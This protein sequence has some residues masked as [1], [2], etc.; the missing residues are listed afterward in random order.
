[1]SVFIVAEMSCNHMG[2]LQ[3]AY[4]IIDAA[5]EAGAD[6][7]KISLDD[8]N[9]GI[10]IDCHNKYF[11]IR[12]GTW[13]GENLHDLYMRT[14]TPWRWVEGLKERAEK[15]G[16]ELFA[17]VSCARGVEHCMMYDLPRFKVSSFEAC[18]VPLLREIKKTGRPVIVS[19][20]K[21][22]E[23]ARDEFADYDASY[24]YCVSKYPARYDDFDLDVFSVIDPLY[25]GISDHSLGSDISIAA[26]AMGAE[27]VEKHFTLDRGNGSADAAFSMEPEEFGH[28]VDGIRGIERAMIPK[29]SK[30]IDRSLCKSIFAV[31]DLK[32]G[33]VFTDNNI[34]CIRPG[35]GLKP[36][37]YYR[38]LGCKAR[39]DIKRGTPIVEAML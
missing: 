11:K 33:E 13:K 28:M 36:K 1:M 22:W 8:P 34:R 29:A 39:H 19:C 38:V 20:G 7:V 10:T 37:E 35:M 6:A 32:K 3:T 17:T 16:M 18:D 23:A 24:L 5:A 26:V 4:Q 21:D 30:P 31:K 2:S 9:G 15:N 25:D 14:R 27:I 12:A